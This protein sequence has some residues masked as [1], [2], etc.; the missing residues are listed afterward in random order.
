[1]RRGVK[2]TSITA[3]ARQSG[4]TLF[5]TQLNNDNNYVRI[6]NVAIPY[7]GTSIT[8]YNVPVCSVLWCTYDGNILKGYAATSRVNTSLLTINGSF[9][10]VLSVSLSADE[11][12]GVVI[13][14]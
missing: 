5:Y 3:S 1:M 14:L 7:D 12:N 10:I 4:Y 2:L 9:S 11:E 8:V 6:E 13:G